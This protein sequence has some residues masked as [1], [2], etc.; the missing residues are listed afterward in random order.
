VGISHLKKIWLRWYIVQNFGRLGNL[1]FFVVAL[2]NKCRRVKKIEGKL[3][4][5]N[6]HYNFKI[7]GVLPVVWEQECW[8][9]SMCMCLCGIFINVCVTHSLWH[10][11]YTVDWV[12]QQCCSI[13]RILWL[14]VRGETCVQ[15]YHKSLIIM[16]HQ[17]CFWG[18]YVYQAA[19]TMAYPVL[20][21]M[22]KFTLSHFT[23]QSLQ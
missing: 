3:I 11:E 20:S 15:G 6:A 13:L 21:Q 1:K 22:T 16:N 9:I 4:W 19:Y 17:L 8:N 14:R 12:W 23:T 18:L 7:F 5:S 10:W 2:R